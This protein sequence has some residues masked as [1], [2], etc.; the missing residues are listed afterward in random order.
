M[1]VTK[2]VKNQ[3]AHWEKITALG[4]VTTAQTFDLNTS[5]VFSM[6][7]G[8]SLSLSIASLA[9]IP[10]NSFVSFSLF[11]TGTGSYTL[12][13]PSGCYTSSGA[14]ITSVVPNTKL[15]LSFVSINKGS[16]WVVS[17]FAMAF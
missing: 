6:T 15:A 10:N 13:L 4:T 3:I 5:T 14:S 17:P 9:A 1:S 7:L 8:A 11:V 16:T 2:P 12:T